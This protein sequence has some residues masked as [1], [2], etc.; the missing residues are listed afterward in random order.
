MHTFDFNKNI[1]FSTFAILVTFMYV[2]QASSSEENSVNT[3]EGKVL[4]PSV[5]S[6]T[7]LKTSAL[8][9][10]EEPSIKLSYT[11]K[12]QR[13]ATFSQLA[14]LT[15][16]YIQSE[17]GRRETWFITDVDHVLITPRDIFGRPKGQTICQHLMRDGRYEGQGK[18]DDIVEDMIS[19]L[20]YILIEEDARAL[21]TELVQKGMT[22]LALTGL[23][24]EFIKK[25][26]IE[27]RVNQLNGLGL[28]FNGFTEPGTRVDWDKGGRYKNGIIRAGSNEKGDALLYYIDNIRKETPKRVFFIDNSLKYLLSVQKACESIGV[29]YHG[30]HYVSEAFELDPNPDEKVIEW[31]LTHLAETGETLDYETAKQQI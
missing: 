19:K 10:E 9:A 4:K 5:S 24:V 29:E 1:S 3:A 22:V 23:R 7:H 25:D 15:K 27:W 2:E 14:E 12:I 17:E 31:Q 11:N 8:D 13:I 6:V 26:L 28:Q 18:V 21:I 30:I 20:E 16:P